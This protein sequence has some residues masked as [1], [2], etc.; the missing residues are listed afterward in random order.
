M[1][2]RGEGG[3]EGRKGCIPY[4]R[5]QREKERNDCAHVS[6]LVLIIIKTPCSHVSLSLCVRA[7]KP[8]TQ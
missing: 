5:M 6:E 8:P 1:R 2:R 7:T 3:R 4:T